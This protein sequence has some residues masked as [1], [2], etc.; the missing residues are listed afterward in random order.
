MTDRVGFLRRAG[1]GAAGVS[2]G[3]LLG[4]AGALAGDGGGDF[5]S[6]P[7]WRFV[8]VSHDT[9]DPLFVATQFGAQDAASLVKCSVQWN[10][11]P[12]RN[13]GETVKA[14]RSAIDRKADGIAVS[15]VDRTAFAPGL[16]AAR[17]AGIPVVAFNVDAAP[18]QGRLSYVGENP[19]AA[20][21]S[22]AGEVSRL[23]PNGEVVLLA[24]EHAAHWVERRLEG[25]VAGLKSK[26]S[27][28]KVVRLTGP[29]KQQQQLIEATLGKSPRARGLVAMDGAGTKAVGSVIE[30]L[31][32]KAKGFHGGGFDLLPSD[33]RLVSE[34]HLGFVV[35]QQAYVQGFA[36]AIQLF[37]SLVSQGAIVPWDTETSVLLRAADV[38]RFVTTKSRFDGSSSRHD[39]PLRRT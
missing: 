16:A 9:V 22:A 21:L 17:K 11:S 24:P 26:R 12:R 35:D 18:G 2:L 15:V 5:P 3:Q 7:R 10:G 37:L 1:L 19:Y 36:P 25:A 31:G 29:A 30:R 8:F 32:L 4:P 20:G 34:G 27:S 13:V 33:L 14:L 28:P 6:H 39:Y 23:V 38:A